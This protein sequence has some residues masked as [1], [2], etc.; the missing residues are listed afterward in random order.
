MHKNKTVKFF[1]C[2]SKPRKKKHKIRMFQNGV[3]LVS[4]VVSDEINWYCL[5][6]SRLQFAVKGTHT[7]K[8]AW[9]ETHICITV[10]KEKKPNTQ[11]SMRNTLNL[12]KVSEIP[13]FYSKIK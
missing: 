6:S 7:K 10:V 1:Q 4:L 12:I 11:I 13:C 5:A 8:T 2:I 9:M 3:L